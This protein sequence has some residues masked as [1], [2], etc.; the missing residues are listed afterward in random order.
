MS[1]SSSKQVI[2][3]LEREIHCIWCHSCRKCID[4]PVYVITATA[5]QGRMWKCKTLEFIRRNKKHL[6]V[7]SQISRLCGSRFQMWSRA[8]CCYSTLRLP[9]IYL[10]TTTSSLTICHQRSIL[11]T[12]CC[13]PRLH[14]AN[15]QPQ[16][17]KMNSLRQWQ[18]HVGHVVWRTALI[19]C[20]D[21]RLP[22][23]K[24]TRL[25]FFYRDQMHL[26]GRPFSWRSRRLHTVVTAQV[27][28][29]IQ[30]LYCSAAVKN[31]KKSSNYL[32]DQLMIMYE[33][34]K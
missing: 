10:Q 5:Q 3:G 22:C 26:Q 32:T 34:K 28:S 20:K 24:L 4:T 2:L 15:T 16:T 12:K 11:V 19:T 21:R 33:C 30:M 9:D 25:S 6:L 8:G 1:R 13:I 31:K 27:Q 17:V 18:M 7:N 29:G 23:F 14:G